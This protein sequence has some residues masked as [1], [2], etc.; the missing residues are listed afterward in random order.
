MK[1]LKTFANPRVAKS[2]SLTDRT[3]GLD[4]RIADY[5]GAID[6]TVPM[7][8]PAVSLGLNPRKG[9]DRFLACQIVMISPSGTDNSNH[10]RAADIL[11]SEETPSQRNKRSRSAILIEAITS[12][13]KGSQRKPDINYIKNVNAKHKE[14]TYLM[15][16][17]RR[18]FPKDQSD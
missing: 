8:H 6:D 7:K 12:G 1:D 15:K 18:C 5:Y 13:R 9:E 4:A 16:Q 2:E 11:S 14:V 10:P 17:K 3:R